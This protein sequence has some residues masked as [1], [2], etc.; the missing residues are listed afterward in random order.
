MSSAEQINS[1]IAE[2]AQKLPDITKTCSRCGE[3]K[4]A[5]EFAR[6]HAAKQ[7]GYQRYCKQCLYK[8]RAQRRRGER[9]RMIAEAYEVRDKL[10][11]EGVIITPDGRA[12][13]G[14]LTNEQQDLHDQ[15]G[16]Y[17]YVMHTEYGMTQRYIARRLHLPERK[18]NK[19]IA[20]ANR[21]DFTPESR[22]DMRHWALLQYEEQIQRARKAGNLSE[23]RMA[24]DAM[25]KATGIL[26]TGGNTL[27]VG[28]I[29]ASKFEERI[30]AL[31]K[32][33]VLDGEVVEDQAPA[34][35]GETAV[36]GGSPA[37][38]PAAEASDPPTEELGA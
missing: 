38:E 17:L 32:A 9:E 36:E 1:E 6:D 31:L 23:A 8:Y 22:E 12:A 14:R 27:N 30:E 15:L 13:R 3:I 7:D 29:G 11:L 24:I 19:M 2:T 34:L 25:L 28:I 18:V 4:P 20:R 16:R 10:R 26:S 37:D 5:H 35:E 21:L 33:E